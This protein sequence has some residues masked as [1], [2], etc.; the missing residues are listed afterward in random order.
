[1]GVN[2]FELLFFSV[3]KRKYV[4]AEKEVKELKQVIE[5]LKRAY[6]AYE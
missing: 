6:I 5:K 2:L 3:Y 1:L 4:A